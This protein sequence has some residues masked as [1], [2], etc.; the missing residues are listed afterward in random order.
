[1][2]KGSGIPVRNYDICLPSANPKN[3]VTAFCPPAPL[4]G[5]SF[6]FYTWIFDSL[7]PKGGDRY[8]ILRRFVMLQNEPP[9]RGV[10][11]QNKT[12][13]QF[14]Q[15]VGG[16]N[17][18]RTQFIQGGWGTKSKAKQMLFLSFILFLVKKPVNLHV[19]YI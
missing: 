11:G 9:F 13:T 3:L 17:K 15:G 5:G 7:T 14:I 16:Q 8:W 6:T 2:R 18:T 19:V 4:K 1:L 10:G 12:R